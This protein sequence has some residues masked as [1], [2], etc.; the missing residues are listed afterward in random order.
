MCGNKPASWTDNL[1]LFP[2]GCTHD[3]SQDC[4]EI[5]TNASPWLAAVFLMM[6]CAVQQRYEIRLSEPDTNL[7]TWAALPKTGP[8]WLVSLHRCR[9]K[10]YERNEGKCTRGSLPLPSHTW[11]CWGSCWLAST[12]RLV[13]LEIGV[14]W[15]LHPICVLALLSVQHPSELGPTM[16]L[17]SK[18]SLLEGSSTT[19]YSDDWVP[20]C[21]RMPDMLDATSYSLYNAAAG[22]NIHLRR[23]WRMINCICCILLAK[24]AWQAEWWCIPGNVHGDEPFLPCCGPHWW[25]GAPQERLLFVHRFV[26][27]HLQSKILI[28]LDGRTVDWGLTGPYA[29][30]SYDFAESGFFGVLYSDSF[31]LRSLV[32]KM[33]FKKSDNADIGE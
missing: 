30:V 11:C 4:V 21:W 29:E 6:C 13:W 22:D 16:E 8:V 3:S 23:V 27:E 28:V 19:S 17:S 33:R 32:A 15:H 24:A 20:F 10:S 2:F 31:P 12:Q 7:S 25:A 1:L 18:Q 5:T 14:A 9:R 26:P